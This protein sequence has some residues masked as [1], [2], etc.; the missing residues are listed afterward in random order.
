VTHLTRMEVGFVCVAGMDP[1]TGAHIRPVVPGRRIRRDEIHIGG[2]EIT[3]GTELNLG[4][5]VPVPSPPEVEDHA[6][7]PA[8]AKRLRDWSSA[9]LG[10]FLRGHAAGTLDDIFGAGLEPDGWTASMSAGS[11]SASLGCLAPSETPTVSVDGYRKVKLALEDEGRQFS[12]TV[13]DL[14]LYESDQKT[15]NSD[16]IRRVQTDLRHASEVFLSVGLSR[17]YPKPGGT[18]A[19]RHW[20]QINNIHAFNLGTP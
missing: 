2:S 18:G 3:I 6:F 14:R 7:A 12:V 15:P 16:A 13:A 11:G 4:H 20:L 1:I 19:P 10:A 8:A 17:P 5:V 9:D